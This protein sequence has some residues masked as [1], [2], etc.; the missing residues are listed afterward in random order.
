[1]SFRVVQFIALIFACTLLA[2]AQHGEAG[3][4]YFPPNYHGDT[5]TGTISSFDHGIGAITLIYD[6]KG[7]TE[8]FTGVMKPPI[9]FIDKDEKQIPGPRLLKVCDRITVY[10][11]TWKKKNSIFMIKLLD[12]QNL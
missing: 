5:W 1:M 8:T 11:L 3:T 2:S 7:K 12:P 10:Y 4:G 9:L 6:H